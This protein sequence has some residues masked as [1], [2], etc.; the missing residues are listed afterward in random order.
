[1]EMTRNAFKLALGTMSAAAVL[2]MMGLAGANPAFADTTVTAWTHGDVKAGPA[3]GER[4]VSY[5]NAG[6]TY[7][8]VCWTYGDPVTIPGSSEQN[9]KWVKLHLNSGAY[10]SVPGAYLRGND[11][12][13][14]P[15]QC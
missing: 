3:N 4:T 6:Y 10:G 5:V 1:M 15:N 9:Y 2:V 13:G 8:G 12:G 7:T 11:P 14:V